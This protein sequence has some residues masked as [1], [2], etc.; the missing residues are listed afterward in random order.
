MK[1]A[2]PQPEPRGQFLKSSTPPFDARWWRAKISSEDLSWARQNLARGSEAS[3]GFPFFDQNVRLR[4]ALYDG[5]PW[6]ERVA[7]VKSERGPRVLLQL[8]SPYNYRTAYHQALDKR[9]PYLSPHGQF[10][11]LEPDFHKH[12]FQFMQQFGPLFI[13]T[14][15]R[16]PSESLWVNLS[17]FWDKH[18]RFVAVSKLWEERFDPEKL[19]ANWE[20][21]GGQ[22]ERLD[23]AAA[24]PLG[25]IPDPKHGHVRLCPSLP[26][27]WD[28]HEQASF[29]SSDHLRGLVHDLVYCELILHTQD[30]VLSW[31]RRPVRDGESTEDELF[32]PSRA[33]TSLWSAIWELF[34][35]DT[36]RYGWRV[37]QICGLLFYPKDRRSVC[38]TTEHQ[39]RWS[40]RAWARRH[41]TGTLPAKRN[42]SH[43]KR[44]KEWLPKS[45]KRLQ[46]AE[47]SDIDSVHQ[48]CT[49]SAMPSRT[50][51]VSVWICSRCGHEWQSK[52][53]AKP[54]RCAKCKTPYWDRVKELDRKTK[55]T[56][57][58]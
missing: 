1:T 32:E 40:K 10:R 13:D 51:A 27:E 7:F 31:T 41:R 22:H 29:A 14:E 24:A 39:S 46:I 2:R 34:G 54:V 38:C 9:D 11:L 57:R 53:N 25:H 21:I 5:I 47:G 8:G 20:A 48:R 37:C 26:W 58:V 16:L 44:Y 55:P 45:V 18:A 4:T 3:R 15:T 43:K 28:T 6:N 17:D 12:A 23:N 19:R 30:C 56:K 33:F 36:R 35:L 50:Q 42:V 49:L 52:D